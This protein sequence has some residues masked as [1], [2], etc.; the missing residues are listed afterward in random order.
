[1][2]KNNIIF[3]LLL[4]WAIC[5]GGATYAQ[6]I[7][8][9]ITDSQGP[10]PGVSVIEKG[11][12]NGTVTDFNGNYSIDLSDNNATL[13][14][15]YVGFETQEIPVAGKTS[16]DVN[17]QEAVSELDELIVVGY[18]SQKASTITGAVSSVNVEQLE[19]R[20]VSNV[21]QALQGQVAGVTITQSTGAPGENVEVRIRGNGT[22]GNNN[23][24]Y[25]IDGIPS[26][27]ISF[28]NP[29][30]IKSMSVLKDAAAASIYGSRAAG[31]VI[32]I[33]TKTGA[34]RSG[35]QVDYYGGI[36]KVANLPNMLN[37]SQY[38]NTVTT[39]WNNAGY[40]GTNPYTADIGRTDFANVDYLDE[41]FELGQTHS[42]QLSTSGGTDKTNFFLSAGY[43]GQNGIVVYDNDKF[44][45]LNLRS[46]I[47]SNITERLKVGT[48]IQLSYQE[49]DQISSRGDAP[50]IIRH[51][52]LR[53]PII[54]VTKDPSDPTYSE[55]DPFT[56]LPFYVNP[57]TYESNKY[58]YSQNPIA[59][60]YFTDNSTESF[61]TFGNVFAEYR[62]LADNS[63][64]FRTNFGADINFVHQKAFNPN[65][66]DDDGQGSE[67]DSG[68]GRQNRPTSLA[69][70]RGQDM[71][72]TWNNSFTYD[73]E[74]G[75]HAISALAGMEFI[76][77]NSSGINASRQRFDY[78]NA[79][80]RY[81]DFGGT[82]QDIWNGGLAEEWALFSYFGSATYSF[83]DKYL[84]TANIRADASSRFSKDNYWGYFPSVSAGW[85]ISK[86]NFMNDFNWLTQLKLR[87]SWGEL[88]NQEIPNYAYLTLYRRDADRYLISRYGNPKLKWESTTQSNV[89]IDFGLYKNRLSGSVDYFKKT[90]SDIL[91][92]ISLPNLV[93][94]VSPTFLNS[95]E[96]S[97][98]GLEFGLS[99][100]NFDHPL[101]FEISGNFATLKNEVNSLHPNLP[102]ISGNVTRTQAGHPL[103]AYYGF[104]QEGIY[105]NVGEVTDHLFGTAN[106][107][108]LP[109]DIK[110]KDLDG[111]GIINDN[112]RNFI[113]NPNPKLT[114]GMNV[115]MNYKK[116]DFSFLFQGVGSVDR[117]NDLKKI[118]D[119]D[120]RPFNYTD[121]ILGAWDGEGSTNTIPRVSFTDNGSSKLSDIFVEDASYLRLKNV[122]LGYTIDVEK[123]G[124]IRLYASGQNLLTFTNYSGLDPESTDL[125]DYGTYPQ[126][127]TLLFGVNA[128]F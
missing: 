19:S 34:D 100:R 79:N 119:Y 39:A 77:N 6:T 41:L 86:E 70:S 59:L 73:K 53:P 76:K 121:H 50:G 52:F 105:Q 71:T 14:L 38:L 66:G 99:Y 24:L 28:L 35:I 128:H 101:K 26:R 117:Y 7:T 46:N 94:D 56:D 12:N 30:D 20:R 108:Q 113:G 51:A 60:A 47:S 118:I 89:G 81:L 58:E 29:S 31:G 107:P 98:S 110:F 18:K 85:T 87:A 93:G 65:F 120:T 84:L 1:M 40:P 122:E 27:E 83:K 48:N 115:S 127:L 25:V 116:F 61:K 8:G 43:Y 16:I 57:D 5:V 74:F 15:S 78:T 80:F 112:D 95:G 88:G 104:I 92:P 75:D 2:R 91:L 4:I 106:A 69:E 13:V 33:E 44:T 67:I 3:G 126:S 68:L 114:Y 54:P 21:T 102:Y 72:F 111:N 63:L 97:N 103:N 11:T 109:G 49:Q 96:V 37:A 90:T 124:T 45:R 123:I 62:F 125:I 17:M 64:K 10:L 9:I 32:V 22:I 36:Q 42:I 23:P 82:E 55:E